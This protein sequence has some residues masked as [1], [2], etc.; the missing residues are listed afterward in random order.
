MVENIE[1]A[2]VLGLP[3]DETREANMKNNLDMWL[4][5]LEK[6]INEQEGMV[7]VIFLSHDRQ[8]FFIDGIS[9]ELKKR[10]RDQFN[11]FRTFD[12]R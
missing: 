1:F 8:E 2:Y 7:F 4:R 11:S 12:D 9:Y 6:E 5:P 10:V 3:R